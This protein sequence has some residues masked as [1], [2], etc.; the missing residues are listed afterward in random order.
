MFSAMGSG[1]Y[2]LTVTNTNGDRPQDWTFISGGYEITM[3]D[4][5]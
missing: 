4:V 1:F 3:D 5:Q 2:G